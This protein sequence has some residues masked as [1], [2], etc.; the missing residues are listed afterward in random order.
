MKNASYDSKYV[1][2]GMKI[3]FMCS[4]LVKQSSKSIYDTARE[5]KPEAYGGKCTVH[6]S[7]AEYYCPTDPD[8]TYHTEYLILF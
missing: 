4:D 2:Y 7:N 1:E 3:F 8:I 5:Q 6:I